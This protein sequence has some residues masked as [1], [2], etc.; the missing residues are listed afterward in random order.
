MRK[1]ML[2]PLAAIAVV[3]FTMFSCASS[4][5]TMDSTAMDDTTT[6]SETQT[7]A[8]DDQ[9]QYN[10]TQVSAGDTDISTD[11]SAISTTNEESVGDMFGSIDD[12]KQHGILDLAS[13]SSNL[14]TFSRLLRAAEMEVVLQGEGPFTVFAPTNEAFANLPSGKLEYLMKAENKIELREMLAAHFLAAKVSTAQF[15]SSQRIGL[16]DNQEIVI[17]VEN[18]AVTI[19]GANIVK[20]NVEASNGMIHVVDAIIQPTSTGAG[21]MR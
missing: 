2:K 17:G 21:G 11:M 15:N 1:K 3:S 13:Q 18:N 8:G 4:T 5:D 9:V 7:M 10:D 14:S 20:P 19:G 16:S 6:M 12:T